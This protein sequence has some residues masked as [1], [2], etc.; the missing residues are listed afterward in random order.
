MPNQLAIASINVVLAGTGE[1][2]VATDRPIREDQL[3]T[4]GVG[5]SFLAASAFEGKLGQTTLLPEQDPVVIAVGLGGPEVTEPAVRSAAASVWRAAKHLKSVT[6][7]LPLTTATELGAEVAL[8]ATVEGMLL[9]S[10]RY[11]ELKGTPEEASV[12]EQ[13]TLVVPDGIESDAVLAKAEAV[14][15]AIALTRDLVNRPG[16]SLS[17]TQLADEAVN[18]AD[19]TGLDVE[20]WDRERLTEERCGGILGVNAGST[21]EPRLVRLT[22]RPKGESRGTIHF[23]GKGITFDTGGL[24]LKSFEGMKEMKI[25]MGGAAAVIGAMA[26]IAAHSPDLTV[27]GTCCCTCL[28]YTSPSPR[29]S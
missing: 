11:D 6:S 27:I 29:D 19:R 28:L 18:A 9:A 13:V 20:V 2:T 17:A 16:G 1:G 26:A 14:A 8:Q 23:V 22:W 15:N 12:L 25:D 5:D 24:N 21:E 3:E 7:L 4:L 10:Y